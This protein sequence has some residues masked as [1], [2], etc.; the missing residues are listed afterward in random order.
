M[1]I[2]NKPIS[3]TLLA[4]GTILVGTIAMVVVPMFMPSTQ[5][6]SD[7]QKAYSPIEL[8]GRDVYQAEGCNNCHT[9]TIRPLKAEVARYG[10]YSKAWE[11]EYDRPFL[12]GSKR[13]GPDLARIGGKYSDKWHYRHFEDARK[14][15]AGSNMPD[16]GFL[17]N[18]MLDPDTVE[19]HIKGIGFPYTSDDIKAVVGKTELDA[20]VAYMQMLG[21]AI[22]RTPTSQMVAE[23]DKNPNTGSDAIAAGQK[24]FDLYCVGCHSLDMSADFDP[25]LVD[26]VWIGYSEDFEDWELFQVVARGTREGYERRAEG[27]MPPFGEMLGKDKIWNLVAYIRAQVSSKK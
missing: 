2:Y 18:N 1:S 6:H 22:P 5:P 19:S 10:P 7:L 23:G 17:A 16:Y 27:G 8:A 25:D 4:A 9:Q 20:L 3:F 21:M 26:V 13:T 15:V 24:T 12:W 14:V 11:F